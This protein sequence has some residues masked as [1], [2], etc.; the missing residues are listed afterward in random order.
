MCGGGSIKKIVGGITKVATL[1]LTDDPLEAGTLGLVKTEDLS[2]K[3]PEIPKT[4]SREDAAVASLEKE[5]ARR[6]GAKGK[7]K[8]ILTSPRGVTT[9]ATGRKTLLGQ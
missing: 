3:L 1:G 8:T 5:R 6:R 9:E 2:P 7:R 4:P